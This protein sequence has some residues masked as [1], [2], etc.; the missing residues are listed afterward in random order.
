MKCFKYLRSNITA[1]VGL[2]TDVKSRM[3]D[4]GKVFTCKAM[5]MNVQRKLYDGVSVS[6]ALH[7]P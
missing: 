6:T 7:G 3:N 5:V 1:D 2:E 4:V